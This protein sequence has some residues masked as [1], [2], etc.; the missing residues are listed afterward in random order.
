MMLQS[1]AETVVIWVKLANQKYDTKQPIRSYVTKQPI[2]S[3]V[4]KQ[5][6][7]SYVTKPPIRSYETNKQSEGMLQTNNSEM[8]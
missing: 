5:P 3:Y 8:F 1:E 2:R 4:T 7:R 6:I